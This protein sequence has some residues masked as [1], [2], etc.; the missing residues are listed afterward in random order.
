MPAAPA[1][2]APSAMPTAAM[3]ARDAE[4]AAVRKGVVKLGYSWEANDVEVP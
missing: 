3:Q 2:D 4:T 1:F